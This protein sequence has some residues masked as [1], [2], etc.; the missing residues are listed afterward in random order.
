MRV[1]G[2][3]IDAQLLS[4][5]REP[6]HGDLRPLARRHLGHLRRLELDDGRAAVGLRLDVD[7]EVAD[8]PEA[9]AEVLVLRREHRPD[10]EILES[11]RRRRRSP[12]GTGREQ[13]RD[14]GARGERGSQH[15]AG[16]APGDHRATAKRAQTA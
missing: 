6:E 13:E 7:G 1:R 2:A 8:R 12:G 4:G 14:D 11:D 10:V 15:A 9:D 16:V 5:I 3:R